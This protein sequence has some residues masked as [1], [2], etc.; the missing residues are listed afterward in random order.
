[1]PLASRRDSSFGR[2]IVWRSFTPASTKAQILRVS[3]RSTVLVPREQS[4][5][6]FLRV[7]VVGPASGNLGRRESRSHSSPALPW[8]RISV[9]TIASPRWLPRLHSSRFGSDETGIIEGRE[10]TSAVEPLRI[11]RRP[12]LLWLKTLDIFIKLNAI[13]HTKG[14]LSLARSALYFPSCCNVCPTQ[15]PHSVLSKFTDLEPY[16]KDASHEMAAWRTESVDSAGNAA[17]SGKVTSGSMPS[18]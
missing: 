3:A 15:F 1:M 12:T 10:L 18:S 11:T 4:K 14:R 8:K 2:G 9:K 5:F 16:C 17:G 6:G 13:A 7:P